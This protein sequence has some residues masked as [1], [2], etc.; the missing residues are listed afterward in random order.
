M[1]AF[2]RLS[3]RLLGLICAIGSFS[4]YANGINPPRPQVATITTAS[5]LN[6]AGKQLHVILRSQIKEGGTSTQSLVLRIDDAVERLNLSDIASIAFAATSA[7]AQ[8]FAKATL[9]RR[10][11]TES[12]SVAVRVGAGNSKTQLVGFTNAGARLEV[13][14]L[15][16]KRIEFSSS[17]EERPREPS[18]NRHVPTA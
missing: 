17:A 12:E 8:G 4:V 1:N 16:C 6:P 13:G 3:I 7:D 9:I 18:G 15:K 14:L 11:G 10:G 2:K 5:C